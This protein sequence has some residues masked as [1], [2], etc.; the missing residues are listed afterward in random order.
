MSSSISHAMTTHSS[1]RLLLKQRCISVQIHCSSR[2]TNSSSAKLQHKPELQGPVK[3]RQ[4][5]DSPGNT[6][7]FPASRWTGYIFSSGPCCHH[8]IC[9]VKI[10]SSSNSLSCQ[11]NLVTIMSSPG[12]YNPMRLMH[13]KLY[14]S[15]YMVVQTVSF[16]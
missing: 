15:I 8:S 11:W 5:M 10:N 2:Q 1:L 6:G 9:Q 3:L 7:V 4:T 12:K 13:Y 14:L 16:H